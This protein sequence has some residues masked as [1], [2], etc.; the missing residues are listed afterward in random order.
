MTS[1]DIKFD[2]EKSGALCDVAPTILEV[3]GLPIPEEMTG[4]S[5][6]KH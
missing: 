2:K 5:I 6:L 1:K 4:S 3:M